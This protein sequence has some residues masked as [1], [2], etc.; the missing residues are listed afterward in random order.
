[1]ICFI[2]DSIRLLQPDIDK[3]VGS[4]Y[5]GFMKLTRDR[6][7]NWHRSSLNEDVEIILATIHHNARRS[8]VLS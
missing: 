3:L 7:T 5:I 2:T 1:M 8:Q 6:E 4:C